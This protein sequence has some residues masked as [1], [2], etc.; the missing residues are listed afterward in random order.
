[1]E[2][3]LPV[4]LRVEGA[5]VQLPAGL[6]L[7]AYRLVQEGLTNALKHARA[8][9]AQVLVRYGDGHVELTVSDDGT[10]GGDG[11]KGGHGLVGMRERVSVYGGELDAGPRPEGGYRLRA[12]LPIA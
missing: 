9:H 12:T 11:D 2:A 10:G 3:G 7:T 8:E 5:P 6:D 4:E 1:R